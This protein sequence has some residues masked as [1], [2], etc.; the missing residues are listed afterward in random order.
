M[1]IQGYILPFKV[2]NHHLVIISSSQCKGGYRSL[3][4]VLW[5]GVYSLR[6]L[7]PLLVSISVMRKT[8]QCMAQVM[9]QFSDKVL[10]NALANGGRLIPRWC[11]KVKIE[12][13]YVTGERR[14]LEKG[15]HQL[16]GRLFPVPYTHRYTHTHTHRYM[17]NLSCTHTYTP[18]AHQFTPMYLFS[19][20]IGLHRHLQH[21]AINKLQTTA[22]T[23]WQK[24]IHGILAC[25]I[26][27]LG[28]VFCTF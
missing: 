26:I 13:R 24:Q 15:T 20:W 3:L 23:V 7:S 19:L 10:E 6:S 2:H 16:R 5:W 25:C 18:C 28:L 22:L 11:K 1:F 8:S 9:D 14:W 17:S 21:S 12:V 27:Q 4:K